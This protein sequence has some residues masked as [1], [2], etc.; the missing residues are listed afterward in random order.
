M[1]EG[2]GKEY[3][4]YGIILYEGEYKNGCPCNEVDTNNTEEYYSEIDE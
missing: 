2:Y 4:E 3:D 1:R